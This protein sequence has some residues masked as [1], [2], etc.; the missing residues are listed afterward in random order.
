M[1]GERYRLLQ[2]VL[3]DRKDMEGRSGWSRKQV[4]WLKNIREWAGIQSTEQK[5]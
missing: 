1:R 2:R 3:T 4:S 5:R